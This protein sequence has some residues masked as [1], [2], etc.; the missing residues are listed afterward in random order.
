MLLAWSLVIGLYVA[1]AVF[2]WSAYALFRAVRTFA[3]MTD[4]LRK[5]ASEKKPE[6]PEES[7]QIEVHE[8]PFVFRPDS[9]DTLH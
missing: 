6:S 7:W 5:A 2:L 9:C 1:I 3:R 8:Q 4:E